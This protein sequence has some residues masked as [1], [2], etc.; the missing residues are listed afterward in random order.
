[1]AVDASRLTHTCAAAD[2]VKVT[3][4]SAKVTLLGACASVVVEGL[5]NRLWVTATKVLEFTLFS[6]D[7]VAFCRSFPDD[8]TVMGLRNL[9]IACRER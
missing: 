6:E 4:E 2:S 8:V 3:A 9:P 7:N 1:M 5:N